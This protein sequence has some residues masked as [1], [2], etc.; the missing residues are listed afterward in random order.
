ML[1]RSWQG[2]I[3]LLPR[4]QRVGLGSPVRMRPQKSHMIMLA[5]AGSRATVRPSLCL[6]G[7]VTDAVAGGEVVVVVEV[8]L[9]ACEHR[10]AKHSPEGIDRFWML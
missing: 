10:C 9:Q 3:W 2:A 8:G 6:I 7:L 5:E 4:P 1:A